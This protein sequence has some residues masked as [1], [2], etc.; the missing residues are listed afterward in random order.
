MR[1]GDSA[2][3]DRI[4]EVAAAE[5]A[6]AADREVGNIE[7]GWLVRVKEHSSVECLRVDGSVLWFEVYLTELVGVIASFVTTR[8]LVENAPDVGS[9]QRVKGCSDLDPAI[10][11]VVTAEATEVFGINS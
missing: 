4:G 11:E 10:I 2:G 7:L 1:Q 8:V 5:A 9:E 6:W 3:P